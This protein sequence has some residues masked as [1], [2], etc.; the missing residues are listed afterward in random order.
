MKLGTNELKRDFKIL[1]ETFFDATISIFGQWSWC[2][3]IDKNNCPK[4]NELCTNPSSSPTLSTDE[5]SFGHFNSSRCYETTIFNFAYMNSAYNLK[6][7]TESKSEIDFRRKFTI[8]WNLHL[9]KKY[10]SDKSCF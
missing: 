4:E 10:I 8:A 9:E 2:I 1:P 6:R 3:N 5:R 7:G